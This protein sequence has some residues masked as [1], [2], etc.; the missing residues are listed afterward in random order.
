MTSLTAY[1]ILLGIIAVERLF[2]LFIARRNAEF[3]RPGYDLKKAMQDRL[4]RL[5]GADGY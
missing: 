4:Q 5:N 2:E 3:G 1:L